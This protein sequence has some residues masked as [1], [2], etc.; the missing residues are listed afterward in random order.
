HFSVAR[1]TATQ[2]LRAAGIDRASRTVVDTFADL[3]VHM[4]SLLATEAMHAANHTGRPRADLS[5]VRLAMDLVG[6][7]R[8]SGRSAPHEEHMQEAVLGFGRWITGEQAQAMRRVAGEGENELGEAA[9]SD[10]LTHLVQ[11]N[12]RVSGAEAFQDSALAS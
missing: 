11:K 8:E 9:S 4:L 10:W 6:L 12:V 7:L 2:V 3:L 5:D 1:I